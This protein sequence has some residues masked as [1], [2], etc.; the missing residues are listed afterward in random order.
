MS[1]LDRKP[2]ILGGVPKFTETLGIVRPLLPVLEDIDASLRSIL[3]S[4]NLTNNGQFVRELEHL[5]AERLGVLHV[6]LVSNA[7]LGL[8]LALESLELRGDVILPA[9]TYCATA[10][11]LRWAG[12]RPV[13][14]DILPDTFTLDPIAVEAAITPSTRAILPVHIY[15][16]PCEIDE[17]TA[18]A[19][20]Y[21]IPLLFDAAHAIGSHYRGRPI[22]LFGDAEVFSF[23][24]T[25]I[26]PVGEGG[27]ITTN[28][29][30]VANYITLARKF[31]DPGDENT[32]FAGTNAKMQ[33][34][35]AILG[36]EALKTLDMYI[37]NRREY[38]AYLVE[39]LGR[40]PG[41]TFQT[42][43][44]YI[45]MNYQNFAILVDEDAFGLSRDGLFTALIAENIMPR[46]YFYPPLHWHEAYA[47]YRAVSLPITERVSNRI[48][49]L[50][51]YSEMSSDTLD[52][53][54]TAIENIHRYAPEIKHALDQ[55]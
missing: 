25:K 40:L 29:Q 28:R 27:M 5:F 30:E 39:R 36:L 11:A 54:C 17:L 43:R 22:G 46:K 32:L 42:I 16:H 6:V 8:V 13:F 33:E 52:G 31:G 37:N 14:V 38:A 48:L 10:H 34:F 18:I 1:P 24:A 2:A 51:F 3:S 12:L 55:S 4:G 23:H 21:G 41:I 9:Y 45:F 19:A 20:R 47:D 7:T 44:P 53:L 15:G 50:P 49:C 26:F 35:N